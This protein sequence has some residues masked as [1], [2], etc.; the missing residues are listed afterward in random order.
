MFNDPL[1]LAALEEE[2]LDLVVE[3][4]QDSPAPDRICSAVEA[5]PGTPLREI[6]MRVLEQKAKLEA[7]GHR[8]ASA[9]GQPP[10]Q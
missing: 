9:S 4:G 3:E 6:M 1:K 2:I 10:A 7:G 5:P 8:P